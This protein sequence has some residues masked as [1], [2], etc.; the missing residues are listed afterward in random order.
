MGCTFLVWGQRQASPYSWAP[1]EPT[2]WWLH[3]STG[4]PN[5]EWRYMYW[6]PSELFWKRIREAVFGMYAS[7]ERYSLLTVEDCYHFCL[8][9]QCSGS[10]APLQGVA[11]VPGWG[12]ETELKLE[13]SL[14]RFPKAF[15]S[16]RSWWVLC[17]LSTEKLDSETTCFFAEKS[18]FYSWGS[19]PRKQ[20]KCKSV[21]PNKHLK[22][23]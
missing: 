3:D 12:V 20:R 18:V 5:T 23:I 11:C 19:Q 13:D 14:Q 10:M 17:L 7:W 21:S 4:L 15:V 16:N 9:L 1:G 8:F 6:C 2:V 22:Q